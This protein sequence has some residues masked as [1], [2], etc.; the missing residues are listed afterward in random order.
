MDDVPESTRRTRGAARARD[1]RLAAAAQSRFRGRPHGGHLGALPRDERPRVHRR[2]TRRADRGDPRRRD[3]PGRALPHRRAARTRRRWCIAAWCATCTV[4]VPIAVLAIAAVLALATGTRR[5]VVLPIGNVLR[6]G[7]LDLRRDGVARAPAD[8]PVLDAGARADRDRRVFGIH[9]VA[10]FDEERART[11]RRP[12]ASP[13]APSRTRRCRWRSPAATTE[14]GFA[15]LC[16]SDVPAIVEFGAFAVFG[17]GCVTLSRADRV[18]GRAGA[19]AAAPRRLGAAGVAGALERAL[20]ARVDA[21]ARADFGGQRAPRRSLHVSRPARR[22]RRGRLRDSAD[23]DRH[24][25]PVVLRRGLAGA[26]RL[27]RGERT[28]R[29]RDPDLRGALGRRPWHL[30]RSR[31][32]CVRSRRCRSAPTRSRAFREAPRSPTR[33]A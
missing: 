5:G 31:R 27:R 20:R 13:R 15:A 6:R 32:R 25:L 16:L 10:G 28:P 26:A 30:P 4:L 12:R 3:A 14:I 11:R 33:C 18:A 24:R 9:M 29:G 21:A 1:G 8:D 2:R 17:V 22:G 7:A 23:R 19:A